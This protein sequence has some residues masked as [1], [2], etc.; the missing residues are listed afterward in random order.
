MYPVDQ[1]RDSA[2]TSEQMK[3]CLRLIKLL[4]TIMCS[5]HNGWLQY[6]ILS[7]TMENLNYFGFGF[8]L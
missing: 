8:E 2:E 3:G 7:F 1:F 6:Q 5:S 4:N